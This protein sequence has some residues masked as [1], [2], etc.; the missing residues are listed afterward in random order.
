MIAIRQ[1]FPQIQTETDVS[2]RSQASQKPATEAGE[3]GVTNRLIMATIGAN[4]VAGN[5]WENRP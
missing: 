1:I 2:D 4:C 3:T 5:R